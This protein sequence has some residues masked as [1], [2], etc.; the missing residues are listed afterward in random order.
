MVVDQ[1][2][3]VR[4]SDCPPMCDPGDDVDDGGGDGRNLT[5]AL[6]ALVA[7]TQVLLVLLVR[8]A[9]TIRVLRVLLVQRAR[10]SNRNHPTDPMACHL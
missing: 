5:P 6:R 8:R 3:A 4:H 7:L 9:L 2:E 1:I 10:L